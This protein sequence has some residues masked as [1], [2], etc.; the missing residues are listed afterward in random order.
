MNQVTFV[1]PKT[2]NWREKTMRTTFMANE[3]N[4]GR[5]WYV[6]DAAVQ[7]LG[8][9]ASEF[10]SILRGKH[11]PAYTPH[12]DRGDYVIIINAETIELSGNKLNDKKYYRHSNYPGGL[13]E[14][15]ANEMRTKYP[16][17][18][19]ETAVRGML[20]KGPLGRKMSQKWSVCRGP[21]H[22]CHA[23]HLHT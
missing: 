17:K 12:A 2:E 1:K 5:M 10:A 3:N 11:K 13:K 20:A 16:E 6:V 21:E 7:R 23:H 15:T 19:L 8:R 22:T 14:R 18:M 4:I 9:L